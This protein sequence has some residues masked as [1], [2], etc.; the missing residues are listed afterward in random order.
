MDFVVDVTMKMLM[1]VI[2][3]QR[4]AII[5]KRTLVFY[6]IKVV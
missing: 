5:M 2:K 4:K 1:T 3:Q 6:Y